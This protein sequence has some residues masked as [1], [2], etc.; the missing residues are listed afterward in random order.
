MKFLHNATIITAEKEAVGSILIEEGKIKDILYKEEGDYIHKVL[1][2]LKAKPEVMELEGK[3][4]MAGG[5]DAHVHFREPGLT[6]KADMSTESMAAAAGG[7]TYAI[8]MPNTSPATVSAGAFAGKLS[9]AK[10]KSCMNLGFHF[11]A[12]N[13]NIE[14]IEDILAGKTDISPEDV[15]G[16][17]VFMGSSTG[18]MRTTP[19]TVCSRSRASLSWFIAKMRRQSG[20]TFRLR[21]R[22]TEMR[23]HSA[24]MKTYAAE[25]H[26]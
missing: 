25:R 4:V 1:E 13:R 10:E 8:D 20:L 14:E 22:N 18:N 17:K 2:I 15:M 21:L 5:I 3:C 26:V 24:N 7:V 16:I 9:L 6:H 19:S 12:T 23:F 11:G